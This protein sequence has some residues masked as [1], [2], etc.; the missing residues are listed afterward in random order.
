[1]LSL[2][3]Q[4]GL[5]AVRESEGGTEADEGVQRLIRRRI[6]RYPDEAKANMHHA[7]SVKNTSQTLQ[8]W[9]DSD[10]AIHGVAIVSAQRS[11]CCVASSRWKR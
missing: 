3:A 1:M 7:R 8:L 6:E 10:S 9:S 11:Y 5:K 4:Q 2:I